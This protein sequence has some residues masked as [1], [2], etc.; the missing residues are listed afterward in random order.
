M[1]EGKPTVFGW[2]DSSFDFFFCY[3]LS[4]SSF[5]PS[6]PPCPL[7]SLLLSLCS[8]LTSLNLILSVSLLKPK[9]C[10]EGLEP[11]KS[12]W[13]PPLD[14]QEQREGSLEMAGWPPCFLLDTPKRGRRSPSLSVLFS[15]G[16][17]SP[18]RETKLLGWATEAA[19][20][21]ITR[22]SVP[23]LGSGGAA[24]LPPLALMGPGTSS[25]HPC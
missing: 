17:P 12:E 3:L 4:P 11:L 5:L 9:C 20:T 15:S 2:F 16:L 10:C 14:G 8:F 22:A 25:A 6:L 13:S 24:P 21:A 19:E 1:D 7:L 23:C 18:N